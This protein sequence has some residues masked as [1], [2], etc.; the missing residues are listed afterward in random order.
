[1]IV[2]TP[3][4]DFEKL[5]HARMAEARILLDAKC[6]DGAYYLVGYAVEFAFKVRII[7]RLMKSD[8]FPER[9]AAEQFY[10]HDLALLAKLAG[11]D[12]ELESDPAVT[13]FWNG[14]QDWNEQSRYVVGK[15]EKEATNLYEDIEKGL[16][17]W[18]RARW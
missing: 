14:V 9:K 13:P 15:T 10:K 17:P 8:G 2:V 18:I 7:D 3:R 11:L 5:M 12:R 6:W 4:Q 16:L 1:M